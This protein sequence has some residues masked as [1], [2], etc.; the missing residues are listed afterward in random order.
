MNKNKAGS[1]KHLC[2]LASFSPVQTVVKP[3][4]TSSRQNDVAQAGGQRSRTMKQK[5]E[6]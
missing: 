1:Q 5:I 2:K 6:R 3:P 4:H